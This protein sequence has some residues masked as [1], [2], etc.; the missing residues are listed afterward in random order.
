MHTFN[1]FYGHK[2]STAL[3][4]PIFTKLCNTYQ[5]IVQ[6][7]HTEFHPPPAKKSGKNDR[8]PLRPY[9]KH[10]F[11]CADLNELHQISSKSGEK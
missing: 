5:H 1:F 11:H 10:G 8:N 6:I 9:G 2:K 4:A 7:F 3:A